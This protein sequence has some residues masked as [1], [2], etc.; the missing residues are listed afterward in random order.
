MRKRGHERAKNGFRTTCAKAKSP[1]NCRRGSTRR[2]I[3][4]AASTRRG[5]GARTARK[6]RAKPTKNAPSCLIRAG[7][8]GLPASK[9]SAT[10]SC[11]TGWTGRAA[12]WSCNRRVITRAARHF[13]A[14]LAGAAQSDRGFGG[15]ARPH[16]RQHAHGRR[17]RLPG[18]HAATRHQA[19]FRLDRRGAGRIRRLARGPKRLIRPSALRPQNSG[20]TSPTRSMP[21]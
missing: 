16:R 14:A 20:G 11:F 2:S 12:I 6:I 13:R 19:L 8:K 3:S 10:S 7:S 18:R 9:P 4:S 21:R 5:S 15:A 1:S 17:A